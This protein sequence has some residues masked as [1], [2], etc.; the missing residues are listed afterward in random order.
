MILVEETQELVCRFRCDGLLRYV[1]TALADLLCRSADDLV[2]RSLL[3]L[4]PATLRSDVEAT[5]ARTASLADGQ[6]LVVNEFGL[7]DG[8]GRLRWFEWTDRGLF[9]QS[10]RLVEVVSVGTDITDR[11]MAADEEAFVTD[12]DALTGLLNKNALLR[13]VRREVS[14]QTARRPLAALYVDLDDFGALND[15]YGHTTGDRVLEEAAERL[16]SVFRRADTVGRIHDDEFVAVSRLVH[17]DEMVLLERR[18]ADALAAPMVGLG[19]LRLS[20]SLG[21]ALHGPTMSADELINA[22][23]AEMFEHKRHQRLRCRLHYQPTAQHTDAA[24]G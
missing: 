20:A 22:A 24:A 5:I 23:A 15:F 4:V 1:N 6:S 12:H 13:A 16:Q 7:V 18:V 9:D 14:D 3:E 17:R 11:R 19:Q 10:G 8:H 21:W 2:G